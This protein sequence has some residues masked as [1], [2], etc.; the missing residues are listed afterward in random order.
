MVTKRYIKRGGKVFGPYYYESYRDNSGRV[1]KR[2]IPDYKPENKKSTF[3][4]IGISLGIVAVLVMVFLFISQEAMHHSI[5][6][7]AIYSGKEIYKPGEPISGKIRL[8][9]DA[10]ESIPSDT[11]FSITLGD[12][13]EEFILSDF[14]D[15]EP[16]YG[17]IYAKGSDL[18][19]EGMVF[20]IPGKEYQQVDFEIEIYKEQNIE[21]ETTEQ[22]P[23]TEETPAEPEQPQEEPPQ[24]EPPAEEESSSPITGQATAE[25][26]VR[27]IS[28][29]TSYENP[30]TYELEEGEKARVIK[31]TSNGE[32]IPKSEISLDTEDNTLTVSTEYT[33]EG[34][35]ENFKGGKDA[36][37]FEIDLSDINLEATSGDLVIQI[38]YEGTEIAY[39]EEP[40]LISSTESEPPPPLTENNETNKT[41]SELKL[42]QEIPNVRITEDNIIIELKDYFSGA[43]W[44]SAEIENIDVSTEGSL[45][46][47]TPKE[48][49]KGARKATIVAGN[50]EETIES[51][52][53]LILVSSGAV[54]IKTTRDQIKIGDPVKWKMQVTKDISENTLNVEIPKK[55][56]NVEIVA[57]KDGKEETIETAATAGILTGNVIIEVKLDKNKKEEKYNPPI[58]SNFKVWFA[59]VRK[60]FYQKL[61]FKSEITGRA[62]EQTPQ[63]NID[64]T[65]DIPLEEPEA[66]EYVI[67]Y[68]TAPP[69]ATEEETSSGK[70]IT[71]SAPEEVAGL[72]TDIIAYTYLDNKI[73]ISQQH[74]IKLYW[75]NHGE[76]SEEEVE[77]AK[78]TTVDK[79]PETEVIEEI[80]TTEDPTNPV[81]T[82]NI[83]S[84]PEIKSGT[85]TKEAILFDAYD[86]DFDGRIDYI[87]WVV[88]HLSNQT[89]ELVIE[90]TNAEHLDENKEFVS[91]IYT[92]VS[93]LDNI[94]SETIPEN[95]YVRVTFQTELTSN[96]DITLYPRAV[97]GTPKIEVYEVNGSETI[98][99]FETLIDNQYNK[100]YL[101]NLQNSQDTFDLKVL[102]GNVQFDHIVD[103]ADTTPPDI[104]FGAGT[105]SDGT[106]QINTDI[107]VD[108][109]TSDDAGDHYAFLDFDRDVLL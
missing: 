25:I 33:I 6:G 32:E 49:F 15:L 84:A 56:K 96:N 77:K 30:F 17:T 80:S 42:I 88:P 26:N 95:H 93:A 79:I 53:F 104:E 59:S 74:Q 10:G 18:S 47:L 62:T 51:N 31:V 82:G 100:I 61:E 37:I 12:I 38:T 57:I 48:G 54:S 14:V 5:T 11:Q 99:E 2:Y 58:V 85:Y 101:T 75:Y 9:L 73:P 27:T 69:E 45:M 22:P 66:T 64:E 67:E 70:I 68:T 13:K 92:N 52:P 107:Y 87:E 21:E 89:Y 39:S 1:K 4:I 50:D 90:I 16:V 23:T 41:K 24:E 46:K 97:N 20:G 35:G 43:D 106:T 44:Y 40:I 65:V 109:S 7:R 81:L 63:Q 19:G 3:A 94:W 55:A 72:Y 103:P 8:V 91:D 78:T 108:L 98:V 76:L 36:M 71:I 28:G 29:S 34:F 86:L 102:N 83:V 105:P 60:K